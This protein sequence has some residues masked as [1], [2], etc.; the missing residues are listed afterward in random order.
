MGP[1]IHRNQ[2][3]D[4]LRAIAVLA[5]IGHHSDYYP[6]WTKAGWVG[7]DLLGPQ[8]VSHFGA[9]VSRI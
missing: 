6:L 1:S 9:F 3:L 8:R 4:V 2:S 7:V 5:V